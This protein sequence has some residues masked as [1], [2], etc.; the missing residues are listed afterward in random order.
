MFRVRHGEK[1]EFA[2]DDHVFPTEKYRLLAASLRASPPAPLEI[3]PPDPLPEGVV[4]AVHTPEFLARI[5]R[6]FQNPQAG[7]QEF[8]APCSESVY[9]GALQSVAGTLSACQDALSGTG[10][11][12]IGGG[13]H[14]AFP[15][16]GEG[17]CILN[18]IA[19]SLTHLLDTKAIASAAVVDV[20]VHQGNGTATCFAGDPRVDTISLHQER[21]YPAWKPPSSLDIGLDDDTDD[22]QYL[23]ALGAALNWLAS[24]RPPGLVLMQ[25]GA[26]PYR[27][28]QLGGLA[29]TKAGLRERDG[30]VAKWCA[31]RGIPLVAVLGGGYAADTA[32]VVAIHRGTLEALLSVHQR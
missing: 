30:R 31:E 3:L 6:Y 16:H 1:T 17:F 22:D 26:D 12:H 19:C 11:F 20:D 5:E 21:N 15:D 28:D 27:H 10:G 9:Q 14:H 2:W 13:F 25:A 29:L 4:E 32:D 18:D 8:E 24:R 23:A 7:M